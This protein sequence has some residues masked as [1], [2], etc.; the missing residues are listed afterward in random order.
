MTTISRY[1]RSGEGQA[2]HLAFVELLEW[3]YDNLGQRD[4]E[5]SA[6]YTHQISGV[7]LLSVHPEWDK[8]KNEYYAV[9]GVPKFNEHLNEIILE[10]NDKWWVSQVTLWMPSNELN[11]EITVRVPDDVI[12]TQIKLAFLC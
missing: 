6:T 1:Y 10:W 9:R 7:S 12:A 11:F 2:M 3:L 5:A 4:G 8:L